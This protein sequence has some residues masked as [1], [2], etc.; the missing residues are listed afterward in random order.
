MTDAPRFPLETPCRL[1]RSVLWRMQRRFY[2]QRGPAAWSEGVVPHH[3]TSNP[4]IARAYSQVILGFLRDWHGRLDPSQP[5]YVV[6]LGAGSGRL[7]F[8]LVRRLDRMISAP[9]AGAPPRGLALRYVMTDVAESNVAAWRTHPLLQPWLADGRLDLARFDA[10]H[11]AAI[12][13][14]RSGATLAAGGLRNPL[15]VI[16]N[17][18]FAGLAVDAFSVRAGQLL[19]WRVQLCSTHPDGDLDDPDVLSRARLRIEPRALDGAYYGD[20]AL[21][22]VL[23]EY[24]GL[25]DTALTFP[26]A[27]LGCLARLSQLSG[28]RL[29]VLA[30]DKGDAREAALHGQTGPNLTLHGSFSIAVNFHAIARFVTHAGGDALIPGEPPFTV[31]SCAFALGTPGGAAETR[32]AYAEAIDAR[33]PDDMC[34]LQQM[35]VNDVLRAAPDRP[36]PGEGGPD[37]ARGP[38]DVPPGIDHW[39]A[40]LRFTEY[41]PKVLAEVLP[42][43]RPLVPGAT[44]AQ[45]D[46]LLRV[47]ARTWDAYFPIGEPDDLGLALGTLAAAMAAWPEALGFLDGSLRWYGRRPATLIALARCHDRLGDAPAARALVDEAI[48]IDPTCEGAIALG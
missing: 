16:A 24:R 9:R 25:P 33:R 27:S 32:L 22:R 44:A 7:A 36:A 19:E 45:R 3:V 17:Y 26:S 47:M 38:A 42:F 6:E 39:L 15:V 46:E 4:A 10:E 29:L 12:E 21:D 35:M 40:Y 5:V 43:V 2:E 48:A 20:P 31:A 37:G 14:E 13:L 8:H 30:T 1:A 18:V 41:D 34:A 28:G 23:A 11:D